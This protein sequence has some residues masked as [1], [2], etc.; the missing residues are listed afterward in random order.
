MDPIPLDPWLEHLRANLPIAREGRDPEGVHQV[1]VA[2]GRLDL[3]LGTAGWRV[4]R[5]DARWL[6]RGAGRVRDLDVQLASDPPPAW[7]RVLEGELATAR[8]ELV[9]RLDDPRVPGLLAALDGLPP[10]PR[11][12][13]ERRLA[14]LSKRVAR[15]GA[16]LEAH[17]DELE[18]YHDLRRSVRRLRYALEW[19]GASARPVKGMQDALG[20]LNDAA[21]TLELL[22]ELD[23]SDTLSDFQ[24]AHDERVERMRQATLHAWRASE[25]AGEPRP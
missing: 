17:P 13:M 4:L 18:R 10:L 21:V 20:E 5:P 19:C 11:E 6:R 2:L 23:G 14:T 22:A 25:F 1:R 7:A 24:A 12:R 16:A 8:A 9:Q 3:W 15:R